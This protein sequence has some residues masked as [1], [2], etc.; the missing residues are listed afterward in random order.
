MKA[1]DVSSHLGLKLQTLT[2]K[3]REWPD[4]RK[5]WISSTFCSF[6]KVTECFSSQ[7]VCWA[8]DSEGKVSS[9]KSCLAT[10]V[11]ASIATCTFVGGW[12]DGGGRRFK[13][14]FFPFATLLTDSHF[15]FFLIISLFPLY[16]GA[17]SK[18]ENKAS[19]HVSSSMKYDNLCKCNI[20]SEGEIDFP[21][22]CRCG[23][24]HHFF[25]LVTSRTERR[26]SAWWEEWSRTCSFKSFR[27]A[28]RPKVVFPC[29]IWTRDRMK[30]SVF[31]GFFC[32]NISATQIKMNRGGGELL[33]DDS[34]VN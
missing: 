23:V 7:L 11:H 19:L 9:E 26:E 20:F 28:E 4:R 17:K 15:F 22:G 21:L 13:C 16:P 2:A 29:N 14:H 8:A 6:K 27:A 31:L 3:R 24:I 25:F 33:W 12:G 18:A 32:C 10:W 1:Q 5:L 30:S 34:T